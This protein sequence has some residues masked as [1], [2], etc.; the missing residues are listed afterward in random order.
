MIRFPPL[1]QDNCCRGEK[2]AFRSCFLLLMIFA[3]LLYFIGLPLQDLNGSD[4]PREAGIGVGMCIGSDYIVP[5]LN[6]QIFLEKPPLF[7]WLQTAAYNVFGFGTLAARLPSVLSAL[8]GI[9]IVFWLT[10]AMGFSPL[11]AFISGLILALA[12]QYWSNGRTC[13]LDITLTALIA[14]SVYSFFRCARSDTWSDRT[15]WLLFFGIAAGSAIMTKGLIGLAIPGIAL[16]GWLLALAIQRRKL[17]LRHWLMLSIGCLLAL[18]PFAVWI[19]LVYVDIGRDGLHLLWLNNFSRFTGNYAEHVE[20]FYYYLTKLEV[21]Q[22]WLIV[23]PFA[24]YWHAR[25]LK[26]GR[27]S[28]H[29]LLLSWSILPVLLLMAA[30][31]KRIVY[32]LPE[33]PVW[34]ILAGTF[35]TAILEGKITQFRRFKPL[36]WLRGIATW[37]GPLLFVGSIVALFAAKY[38]HLQIKNVLPLALLVLFMAAL[39][40]Y[41]ER[42]RKYEHFFITLLFQTVIVFGIVNYLMAGHNN[43]HNSSRAL[44]TAAAWKTLGEGKELILLN[45]SERIAGS[46]VFYLRSNCREA[47]SSDELKKIFSGPFGSRYVAIANADVTIPDTRILSKVKVRK[48]AFVL[49]EYYKKP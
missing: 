35:I 22:P 29:L 23:L 17:L 14:W 24:I 18:V 46:A 49:L 38:V 45:P 26:T 21:F 36:L 44:F 2:K 11:A 3:V 4:E 5:V 47:K 27:G 42:R 9:A 6:G 20:P 16:A 1:A 41:F 34:A 25:R 7:Y 31:G 39:M 10:A 48:D 12:P 32:L 30:A 43:R 28:A 19:Y 13:M 15:M 33:N 40:I 37:L 8:G